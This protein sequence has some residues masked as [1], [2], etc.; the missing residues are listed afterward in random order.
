MKLAENK[1]F[2]KKQKV[3][4]KKL[5]VMLLQILQFVSLCS[6]LSLLVVCEKWS[7][8]GKFLTFGP[9]VHDGYFEIDYHFSH[10]MQ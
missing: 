7:L 1:L 8:V 3:L 2:I 6:R 5:F 4:S 9:C 10:T